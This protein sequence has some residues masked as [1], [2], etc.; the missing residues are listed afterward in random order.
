MRGLWWCGS[1]AADARSFVLLPFVFFIFRPE[2]SL[3]IE[4][5]SVVSDLLFKPRLAGE[6]KIDVEFIETV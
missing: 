4:D 3:V 1:E 6:G 2:R 5:V